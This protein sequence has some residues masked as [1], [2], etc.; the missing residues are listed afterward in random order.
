MLIGMTGPSRSTKQTLD[1]SYQMFK[2]R[3]TV[4]IT[5]LLKILYNLR[6]FIA[7]LPTPNLALLYDTQCWIGH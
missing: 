1:C 4:P 2:S 5:T 3:K 6:H 7:T